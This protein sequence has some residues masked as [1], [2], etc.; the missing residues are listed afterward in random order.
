MSNRSR[1]S[2]N[3]KKFVPTKSKKGIFRII[4]GQWRG[5]KLDFIEAEGLRPSL[6][7]VRETLFN[8]LQADIHGAKVLDLFA[9]AGSLG[10]E[11]LSRGAKS[12]QFVELNRQAAQKIE[13]NLALLKTEDGQLLN[14]DAL[15]FIQTNQQEFEII[16]LDPPFHKGIAQQ[17]CDLLTDASWLKTGTLIYLEMEQNSE[18]E[19]PESWQ[20][21]KDKKAGQL[22][23]RLYRVVQ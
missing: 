12:V 7:R 20:L 21:L 14:G 15:K 13:Q 8:W 23:Y 5:R 19:L 18:L 10:I 1:P 11:A 6:D 3:T 2:R 4:G 17:A 22:L 9:G 16:M